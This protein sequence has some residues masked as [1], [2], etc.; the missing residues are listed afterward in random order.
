MDG[1]MAG[2]TPQA[3]GSKRSRTGTGYQGALFI[4]FSVAKDLLIITPDVDMWFMNHYRV[5]ISHTLPT[6]TIPG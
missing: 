2:R 6:P 5:C 4:R 3:S 1:I